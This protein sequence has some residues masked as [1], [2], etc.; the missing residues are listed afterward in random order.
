MAAWVAAAAWLAGFRAAAAAGRVP[1][2]AAA[3]GPPAGLDGGPRPPALVDLARGNAMLSTAVF[4]LG[5]GYGKVTLSDP[6]DP[7]LVAHL[8]ATAATRLAAAAVDVPYSPVEEPNG[9]S[10]HQA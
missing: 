10:T 7:R 6:G 1:R 2:R 4:R 8:A 3:G 5:P 9:T